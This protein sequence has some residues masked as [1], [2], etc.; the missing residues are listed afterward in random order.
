MEENPGRAAVGRTLDF[1]RLVARQTGDGYLRL[2]ENIIEY[3]LIGD[4]EL[5]FKLG[6]GGTS[7][8]LRML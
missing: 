3:D 8:R 7:S 1:D 2:G 6:V 4:D 5:E